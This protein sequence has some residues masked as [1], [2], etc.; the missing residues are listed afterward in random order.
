MV[1]EKIYY[2][3][4]PMVN[5]LARNIVANQMVADDIAQEVFIELYKQ[6]EQGRQIGAVKSWLYRVAANRSI[7]YT[8]KY[9]RRKLV[10]TSVEREPLDEPEIDQEMVDVLNRTIQKMSEKEQLLVALYSE[11]LSYREIAEVA[12]IKVTSVGKTLS[13]TL[14]RLR[15]KFKKSHDEVC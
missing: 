14:D 8:R 12:E 2:D 6:L 3:Y 15:E 4:Y 7:S 9:G 1:F 13:R 5:R 10:L 11:G